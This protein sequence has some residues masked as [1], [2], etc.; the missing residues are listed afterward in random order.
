MY[1]AHASKLFSMNEL[2]HASFL[3]HDQNRLLDIVRKY[4]PMMKPVLIFAS[5]RKG[6][7]N[8]GTYNSCNTLIHILLCMHVC[9]ALI[10]RSTRLIAANIIMNDAR[11][12]KTRFVRNEFQRQRLVEISSSSAISDSQQK[13]TREIGC[14]LLRTNNIR[15]HSLFCN[16]HSL[17]LPIITHNST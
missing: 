14:S 1:R 12:T 4:N 9:F 3:A 17:M 6:A 11:K 16:F 2:S 5:S 8:A 13:G 10:F 15:D 7:V